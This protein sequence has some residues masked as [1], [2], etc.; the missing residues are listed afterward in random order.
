MPASTRDGRPCQG[1]TR[2]DTRCGNDEI[3]GLEFCLL[4]VPDEYLEEAE[5]VTG[6]RRCRHQLGAPDACHNY[7]VDGADPVACTRHGMAPG[8]FAMRQTM[9]RTVE[10][11]LGERL[12]GIM[13]DGGEKL[14][15]PDPVSDP[16]SELMELAAE[17]KAVKELLRAKVA[18]MFANDQL[19]YAH[20][21]AGEQLRMEVLLYERGLDRL[22]RLLLDISKLNIAERLTGIRKQ[23][24]DMIERAIDAA[25]EESGVGFEGK[26]VAREAVRR[27]LKIVA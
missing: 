3:E 23:T 21:K 14:L 1:T 27:H 11:K 24:A 8:S 20:S 26:Q 4:H 15:R 22:A 6:M 13:A 7:A 17:V 25:L 19:R 16:L 10:G 9:H 18:P 5:D 2:N 12:A